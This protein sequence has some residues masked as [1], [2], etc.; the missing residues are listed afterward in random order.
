MF[1]VH[2]EG[3]TPEDKAEWIAILREVFAGEVGSYRV[4]FFLAER[5]WRFRLDYRADTDPRDELVMANSPDT[6][7]YNV[8]RVLSERG[9]P[10]DPTW[11]P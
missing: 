5:G 10:I 2:W 11:L 8:H 1:I 9:K 6:V 4:S 3:Q 7:A